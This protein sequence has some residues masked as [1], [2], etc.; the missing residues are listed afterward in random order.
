M[1]KTLSLLREFSSIPGR[2]M[3]GA[4]S[5]LTNQTVDLIKTDFVNANF[6]TAERA[7]I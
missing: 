5:L 3:E 4:N 2:A 7:K 1:A 6:F